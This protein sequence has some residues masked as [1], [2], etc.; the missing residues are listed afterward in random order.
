MNRL[1]EIIEGWKNLT[2]QNKDIEDIAKKRIAICVNCE[3]LRKNNTC[4]RC[5]C[6]MPAKT[7]SL[8]SNCPENLW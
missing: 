3:F 1:E 8:K 7:R 5:G 4:R 6:Y 2:F